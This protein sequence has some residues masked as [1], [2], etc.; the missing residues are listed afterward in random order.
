MRQAIF[1]TML[2]GGLLASASASA[3]IEGFKACASIADGE[4]RLACYDAALAASDADAARRLAEQRRAA[5][6]A[7]AQAAA[8]AKARQ[9]QERL[10]AFGAESTRKGEAAREDAIKQIS[11]TITNIAS[12]VN[13]MVITLDNGQVWRQTESQVL[14]PVREGDTVT[15]RRGLLGSYRMTF[16]RQQRTIA[17]KRVS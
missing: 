12:G 13:G 9:E 16:D 3:Q 1:Y 14:P 15:I 17:V 10:A 8:E 11:A 7:A 6:L 4:K 2:A 5:E